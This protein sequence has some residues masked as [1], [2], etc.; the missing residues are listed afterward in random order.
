MTIYRNL[1]G[2][3]RRTYDAHLMR[4]GFEHPFYHCTIRP[5]MTRRAM[6]L[7]GGY[8]AWVD[9]RE[10]NFDEKWKKFR[11]VADF[12]NELGQEVR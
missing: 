11:P 4:L 6:K 10:K 9:M 12:I 1:F 5:R 8:G 7:I 2:L 3:N